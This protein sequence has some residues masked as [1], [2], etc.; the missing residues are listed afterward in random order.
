[1]SIQTLKAMGINNNALAIHIVRQRTLAAQNASSLLERVIRH[2]NARDYAL[3][4]CA[5]Q[6]CRMELG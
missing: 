3:L 6:E 4:Q 1:M 2:R 5:I